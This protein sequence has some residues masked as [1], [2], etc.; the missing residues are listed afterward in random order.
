MLE[1]SKT[2]ICANKGKQANLT[3]RFCGDIVIQDDNSKIGVL[4]DVLYTP[5]LTE[6][7]FSLR[8]LRKTG[9]SV[10]MNDN[11]I[12]VF[13]TRTKERMKEGI[14]KDKF[15]WL[16]FS[17]PLA[18]CDKSFRMKVLNDLNLIKENEVLGKRKWTARLS[19]IPIGGSMN[20]VKVQKLLDT[21]SSK[22]TGIN[23]NDLKVIH[24]S[25]NVNLRE[26]E[27]LLWHLRLNH[28]SKGCLEIAAKVMSEL[29]N[30][31]FTK[32]IMDCEACKLAKAKQKPCTKTRTRA[33]RPLQRLYSDLMGPIR[34]C[35]YGA[36]ARYIVTLTDDY[37]RFIV[38]YPI[39]N[40]TQVHVVMANFL[41]ETR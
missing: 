27:G 39:I 6:N 37:S 12:V 21:N 38:A 11:K 18:N 17:L 29:R 20:V 2:I 15:W 4:K 30:V 23:V 35:S 25:R 28:A 14:F 31:K 22:G 26:C 33:E 40:K 7:L 36:G 24:E 5:N 16:K 32:E 8:K 13:D 34:P 19:D 41:N 9:L 3:I 10:E 1:R